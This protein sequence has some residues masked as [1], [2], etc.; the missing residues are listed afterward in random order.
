MDVTFN[1]YVNDALRRRGLSLSGAARALGVSPGQLSRVLHLRRSAS[2]ELVIG[3]ASL[4]Q[5]PKDQLIA[6]ANLPPKSK[7]GIPTTGRRR[8][9]GEIEVFTDPRF[10]DSALFAWI[11]AAQPLAELGFQCKLIEVPWRQVSER[12]AH[13]T[14]PAIGFCNRRSK[15]Q[16][17]SHELYPALEVWQD[18]TIYTG[19]AILARRGK[20]SEAPR[21]VE[22]A[23]TVLA[24][25]VSHAK[26]SKPRLV[27]FGS[28]ST[29]RI[30]TE[31]T[32]L[33]TPEFFDFLRE[34]DADSALTSF[35]AG[36]GDL[37]VGGLPQRMAA[38][39]Q[40]CVPI[41]HYEINP[42][43]F[44]LNALV[45]G[46]KVAE[47]SD[48]HQL[49]S[50]VCSAWFSSIERLDLDSSY[51]HTATEAIPTL[52][53]ELCISNHRLTHEF[54]K[55]MLPPKQVCRYELFPHSPAD[56]TRSVVS[57][58][59]KL[60]QSKVAPT[61]TTEAMDDLTA[62]VDVMIDLEHNDF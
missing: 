52:L 1:T 15:P 60:Q 20:V 26:P 2:E 59:R 48:R 4:L 35:L 18:L 38:E 55:Q 51:C 46:P 33:L 31:L 42:A 43:L 25:I 62:T 19:Y 54:L 8:G 5:V 7:Q 39:A 10:L 44:S 27:S 6:L 32:P 14:R 3:L 47:L 24:S 50:M 12:V 9:R 13:S 30:P 41:V 34:T 53:D 61:G 29:W 40:G 37:F 36:V 28:D 49:L 21:S 58:I 57:C 17:R 22:A 11:L 56:L 45:Y 23:N 16:M